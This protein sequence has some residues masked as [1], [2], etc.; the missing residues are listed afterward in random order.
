MKRLLHIIATPRE[1]DSRTLQVSKAFLESFRKKHPDYV[2]GTFLIFKE[3]LPPIGS[4]S[5]GGKY[6]LMSGKELSGPLKDAWQGIVK[7]IERF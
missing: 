2:I 3:N 1:E 4:K 6:V 5:I 7:H